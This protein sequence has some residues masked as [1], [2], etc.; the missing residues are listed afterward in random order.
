MHFFFRLLR[1]ENQM[2]FEKKLKPSQLS[3]IFPLRHKSKNL[4]FHPGHLQP[5]AFI[6]IDFER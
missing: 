6:K 1:K 4:N 2:N 3:P 5:E